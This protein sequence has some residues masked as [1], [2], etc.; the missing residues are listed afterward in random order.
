MAIAS[1]SWS[2]GH[3]HPQVDDHKLQQSR[4]QVPSPA[5]DPIIPVATTPPPIVNESPKWGWGAHH[6]R[7]R[8]RKEEAAA[9]KKEAQE[10]KEAVERAWAEQKKKAVEVQAQA[11]DKVCPGQAAM[12]MWCG[13]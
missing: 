1:H 2:Y 10:I 7:K 8:Q 11:S 5:P 6:E 4:P 9:K 12:C 3:R 13:P